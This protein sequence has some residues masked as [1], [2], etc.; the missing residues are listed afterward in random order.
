MSK[1]TITASD[2]AK[3]LQ[4][5]RAIERMTS[6]E[7][8]VVEHTINPDWFEAMASGAFIEGDNAKEKYEFDNGNI[9]LSR[10]GEGSKVF[11]HRYHVY[12]KEKL[13]AKIHCHPRMDKILKPDYI[14]FQ[15]MNNVLYEVGWLDEI[16]NVF[17]KLSWKMLNL[18]R[19]DIA[20]DGVQVMD[21]I[22][23]YNQKKIRRM[24]RAKLTTHE[25][26]ENIIEGFDVGRTKGWCKMVT[27]Y[28]KTK[29]LEKSN[30]HYIKDF[31]KKTGLQFEGREVQR[32]EMKIKNEEIKKIVDFDW[33]E[34]DNFEYLATIFRTSLKNFFEFIE[35]G[36]DTN[37][38]RLKKIEF[39][40][41]DFLG[42]EL[43][44]RYSTKETNE[45][46]R[47]KQ[48]A[49][50]CYWSYLA[51]GRKYYADI[52]QELAINVNC[53]DWFVNKLEDW[54]HEYYKKS[55]H[56][57]DG[58]VSFQY[59]LHFETLEMNKQLQLFEIVN[60]EKI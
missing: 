21:L 56:N 18:T 34:L 47:M 7:T 15:V 57:R 30:K 40:N 31:W 60:K 3:R 1:Q 52:A 51:S 36:T 41:W 54:K 23:Q 16:K 8:F 44:P 49:K 50:T 38:S 45:V 48:G 5:E 42:A 58:L 10:D 55:G 37:K 2:L 4:Y 43:L 26:G 13:F 20:L 39:I 35:K 28:N 19:F 12:V 29:E 33:K 6:K 32:L 17:N 9:I 27:G 25:V 14:Q 53:L 59:L 24:G 22:D 46:Y 11:K